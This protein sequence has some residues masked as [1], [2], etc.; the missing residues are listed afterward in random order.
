M[1]DFKEVTK[2]LTD[3]EITSYINRMTPKLF[4]GRTTMTTSIE[5]QDELNPGE[6]NPRVDKIRKGVNSTWL[7]IKVDDV[8][9]WAGSTTYNHRA[10]NFGRVEF[11]GINEQFVESLRDK[12]TEILKNWGRG[13]DW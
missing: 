12:L 11:R 1:I 4:V 3:E 5:N 6:L 2:G 13:D 9:I 8:N 10:G 7:D